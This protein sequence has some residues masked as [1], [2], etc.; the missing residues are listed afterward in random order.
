MRLLQNEQFL[1][2][3]AERGITLDMKYKAP[4]TLIMSG[5]EQ[6]AVPH[7]VQ[8]RQMRVLIARTVSLFRD[9][10]AYLWRRG[11]KWEQH[12]KV[13]ADGIDIREGVYQNFEK[14]G[15]PMREV[16][17]CFEPGEHDLLACIIWLNASVAWKAPDDLFLV[18]SDGL[19]LVHYDSDE[20]VFI[21]TP[22]SAAGSALRNEIQGTFRLERT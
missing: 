16:T 5:E 7:P 12:T 1:H 9:H 6:L 19:L 17:L 21:M 4:Q 14:L 22:R 3:A 15:I 10:E 11:G 20:Y 13:G 2:W 18:R 8:C